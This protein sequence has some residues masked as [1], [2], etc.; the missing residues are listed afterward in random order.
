MRP[1]V[2]I[3]GCPAGWIAVIWGSSLS[4]RLYRSFAEVLA[5]KVEIIAVDMPIGF[6]TEDMAGG[7]LA[8]R[9]LRQFLKIKRSSV[10]PAPA[11]AT[12]E[13]NPQTREIASE[14]NRRNSNPPKSVGAQTFGILGKMHEIDRLMTPDLQRRVFETHPEACFAIM[15][16][17]FP[18]LASKKDSEGRR[19]REAA[20]D[21]A[22]FPRHLLPPT[23]Y[24]KKEVGADDLL[25]ACACAWTARR[26]L[27]GRSIRFPANPPGDAKGLRMEINA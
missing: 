22:G 10:F 13:A 6:L 26:I 16:D 4:H 18:I 2:G 12:V 25:D 9:S 8:E 1:V 20:L 5:L 21:A 14:I 19:Q 27:E 23:A 24:R 11:R 15:N 3:D 7:R 17:S